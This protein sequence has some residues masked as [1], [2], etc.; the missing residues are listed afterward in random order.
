MNEINASKFSSLYTTIEF[1]R[2]M[3]PLKTASGIHERLYICLLF[4]IDNLSGSLNRGLHPSLSPA[5][6]DAT[7]L[8]GF[9]TERLVPLDSLQ[10]GSS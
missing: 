3:D 10:N 8:P 6:P 4:K 2:K 9:N 1:L 7:L 5:F